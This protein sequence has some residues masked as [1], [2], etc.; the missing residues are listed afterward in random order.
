MGYTP[1]AVKAAQAQTDLVEVATSGPWHIFELADTKLVQPLDVQPVVVNAR[2]GDQRERWLE[3]G[4]SYF[5]HTSEWNAL[6]VADGPES[7]QRITVVPDASRSVGEPGKAGRQVDIVKTD[8]SSTIKKV[9]LDPVAVSNVKLN[10]ESIS[11][12]V[13]KVGIPVLVNVSY[14]PNWKVK[15]ASDVYRAAPNMMVVVPTA[16]DVKLSYEP[17][18][19]DKGAYV[20]TFFGILWVAYMFRNR[21]RYGVGLPPLSSTSAGD[22]EVSTEIEDTADNL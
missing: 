20:I 13:D 9:S 18:G 8:A 21:L 11:F 22:S 3:V 1:E 7:W 17:S 2:S 6:P 5:Q 10:N 14:F 15:G 16:K 12:S 19:S 4:S